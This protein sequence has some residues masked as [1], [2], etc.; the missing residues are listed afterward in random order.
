MRVWRTGSRAAADNITVYLD[1]YIRKSVYTVMLQTFSALAEPNRL[2]IVEL[3]RRGPQPVAAIGEQLHLYQAQVS[4]HLRVLRDAGLVEVQPRAQQR[5]YA[6]RR[7]P[8]R[9][10]DAW[11]E[12]FRALWDERLSNLERYLSEMPGDDPPAGDAHQAGTAPPPRRR[13]T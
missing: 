11:L 7:E 12:R 6:L 1:T 13:G 5:L 10:L 2:A 3:L 8:M 4:K 9:D